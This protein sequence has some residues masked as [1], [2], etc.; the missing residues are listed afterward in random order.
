MIVQRFHIK[1]YDWDV[2]AYYAVHRYY[3]DEIVDSLIKIGCE[4]ENL[5]KSYKNLMRNAL[6]TGLTYSN[7]ETRESVMVVALSSDSKQFHRCLMHEI[8]HL[9]SHI[10]TA[11]GISEK[12]EEVCYLLDDI[13]D[14][15]HDTCSSLICK[16]C[17]DSTS[18]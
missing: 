2:T 3:V 9:Q 17:R 15:V 12:S 7:Y 5:R 13:I 4:G 16:C 10:A 8:R 11:D 18:S 1:G 14:L 6:N